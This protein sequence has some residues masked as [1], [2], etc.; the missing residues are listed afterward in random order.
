MDVQSFNTVKI[1]FKRSSRHKITS[2][3]YTDGNTDGHTDT[4]ADGQTG[5]FQYT[6]SFCGGI[7]SHA[8]ERA[9]SLNLY[10][11]LYLTIS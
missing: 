3:L 6:H 9:D 5:R 4:W 11:A 8:L 10:S 2:I 1:K 7:I